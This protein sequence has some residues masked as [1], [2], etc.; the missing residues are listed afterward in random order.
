[1]FNNPKVAHDALNSNI[2]L[3]MERNESYG[4][5]VAQVNAEVDQ[6]FDILNGLYTR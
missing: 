1:M 2:D 5:Y 4:K 3:D 6:E